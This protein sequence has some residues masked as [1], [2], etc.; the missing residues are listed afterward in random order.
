MNQPLLE[1][2]E[3]GELQVFGFYHLYNKVP[4]EYSLICLTA[5][6][7]VYKIHRT[8]LIEKI[9]ESHSTDLE[10]HMLE[11]NNYAHFKVN[12]EEST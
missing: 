2:F 8:S 4:Y 11:M 9:F 7:S 12:Q 6:G 1:L 10:K 3:I 5:K